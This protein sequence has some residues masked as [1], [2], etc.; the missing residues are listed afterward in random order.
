M[1]L[2]TT[3]KLRCHIR[4]VHA[5]KDAFHY[6]T[7][8]NTLHYVSR[9]NMQLEGLTV[10]LTDGRFRGLPAVYLQKC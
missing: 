9:P 7:A 3:N 6:P 2:Q 4:S 8:E 10:H 5:I 1:G